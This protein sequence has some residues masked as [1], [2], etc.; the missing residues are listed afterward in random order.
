MI[1]DTDD[2]ARGELLPD[3]LRGRLLF[4]VKRTQ[5]LLVQAT[6]PVLARHGLDNPQ[7]TLLLLIDAE[8][9]GSQQWIGSRLGIDRTTVVAVVDAAERNGL[10]VRHRNPQDRRA[11]VVDVTPA[12]AKALRA[13]RAA[14]GE[15]ERLVTARLDA[16]DLAHL[17]RTLQTL[18][19]A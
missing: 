12:G 1:S 7:Y 4:L 2:S 8:G 16:A 11:N 5:R 13:A 10:V 6:E 14:V 9:P 3:T 19:S 17:T 15:A 18:S